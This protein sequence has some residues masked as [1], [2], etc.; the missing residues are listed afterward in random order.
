MKYLFDNTF[1]LI[2]KYCKK[3]RL[4]YFFNIS[5]VTKKLNELNSFDYVRTQTVI[6]FTRFLITFSIKNNKVV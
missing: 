6:N 2:K 4:Y 5:K 1:F 3:S